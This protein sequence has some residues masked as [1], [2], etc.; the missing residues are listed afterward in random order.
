MPQLHLYLPTAAAERVR[1]RASAM[2]TTVSRYLAEV[3][4]REVASDWPEDYFTEVAGQWKGERL[5]R[6]PQGD[7]ESREDL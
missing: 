6:P 3:V 1:R 5:V 2:G 7:A 4:L